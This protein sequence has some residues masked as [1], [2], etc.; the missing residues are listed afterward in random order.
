MKVNE[1]SHRLTQRL[2]MMHQEENV[3]IV[4]VSTCFVNII[5]LMCFYILHPM[6]TDSTII[7]LIL[8]Y[9]IFIAILTSVYQP[10]WVAKSLSLRKSVFDNNMFLF[11][12]FAFFFCL[13]AA[14]EGAKLLCPWHLWVSYVKETGRRIFFIR[15]N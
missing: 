15:C 12:I 1:A 6:Y 10:L 2:H 7:Y 11:F 5:S 8:Y 4:E 3:E 9:W 14:L 13:S